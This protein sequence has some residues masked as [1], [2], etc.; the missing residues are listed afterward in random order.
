MTLDHW[1][2]NG[3]DLVC[4]RC[5]AKGAMQETRDPDQ[6]APP[7]FGKVYCL[8]CGSFFD[9]LRAPE[10]N[11]R[12]KTISRERREEV[13]REYGNHCAHCGQPRSWFESI[14]VA[15]TIQHAPPVCVV[16]EDA[17]RQIPYCDPCNAHAEWMRR[18]AT[19]V[20]TTVEALAK[21]KAMP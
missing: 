13:W 8:E 19:H 9:W 10:N 17:A 21:K 12:R 4:K 20:R 18:N 15:I 7:H 16:G 1:V 3:A 6:V 14:R 11:T 2:Q 5:K